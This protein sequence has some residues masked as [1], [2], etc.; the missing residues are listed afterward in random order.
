MKIDPELTLSEVGGKGYQLYQL[1]QCFNVPPFFVISLK[2]PHEIRE[3][4]VQKTILKE[5]DSRNFD[6]MAVRSSAVCED[7]PQTSFAGMFETVLCVQPSQLITAITKVLDSVHSKR[8][9][10]YCETHRINQEGIKMAVVIQM[11]INGQV[12]GVCFTRLRKEID[13]LLIEACYGL[14]ETLVSGKTTPDAYIV[15]RTTLSI[16]RENIGYQKLMLKIV[17]NKGKRLVYEEVPFHKR[18]SRKLVPNEIREIA[19]TCLR[20]EQHLHFDAADVEWTKKEDILYILQA[21]QL[22]G[23]TS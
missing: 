1:K 5:C 9:I 22:G 7:S 13:S 4:T 20:I 18:N 12:S 21:R 16:L 11:M 8:V 23:F 19:E 10:D 3:P 14:G 15:D 6:L 2:N 17:N